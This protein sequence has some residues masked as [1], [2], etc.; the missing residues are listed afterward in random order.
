MD[1]GMVFKWTCQNLPDQP[2]SDK[3]KDTTIIEH[4]FLMSSDFENHQSG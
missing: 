3:V 2:N 4:V 1:A